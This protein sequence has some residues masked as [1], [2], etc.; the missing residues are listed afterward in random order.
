MDDPAIAQAR[1]VKAIADFLYWS[2]FPFATIERRADG[3]VVT[4]SDARYASGA[5]AGRFVRTV[6]LPPGAPARQ[7]QRAPDGPEAEDQHEAEHR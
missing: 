3:T 2:R 7:L 4:I 5:T 1:Q 6:R